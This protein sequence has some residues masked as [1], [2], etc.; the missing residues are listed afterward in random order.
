MNGLDFACIGKD[1]RLSLEKEFSKE[2]VTQVLTEIEG[3]NA[4][5]P[6]GFT[7]AFFHK[8][9]RVVE[10]DVMAIFKYFHKYSMFERS[11]NASFLSLIPRKI[12]L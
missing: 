2:E 7:M 10:V 11:L 12:M 8:Y 1:E 3:D 9:W 4:P 5:G 6:D